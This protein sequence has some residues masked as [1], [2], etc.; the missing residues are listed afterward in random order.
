MA[1]T[2]PDLAVRS[3]RVLTAEGLREGT[4]LIAG[5][6]I[7]D[8]VPWDDLPETTAVDDVGNLV[9]MPGLVDTHVHINEPGRT[10]W[11]GFETATKAAAAGGITTLGDMP[12]NSDPVTT[13]VAAL[14]EKVAAADG[15]LWAD[16]GFFGGV[17]PSNAAALEPLVAAGVLGFK[18][19]LTFS[20]IDEFPPVNE[21]DLRRVLPL[22]TEA[23]R[24]LLVHAEL[25][26]A[27]GSKR[28]W[29]KYSEYLASRPPEWEHRAIALL[30]AL[31]REYGCAVHIVHLSSAVAI[32]ALRSAREEGL[33]L[34]VET[35]P[36]YLFFA[37]EEITDGDTRFKCAPPIRE[38]DNR[39]RLWNALGD[40]VIDLVV[41]DHSPCPPE[42][43]QLEAG[44]FSQAWGGIAS[45]QFS[46]PIVWTEARKHGHSIAE[47]AAWMC[48]GPA[49]LAGLSGSKGT[50]APGYD[51]DLA[52][53]NP[54]GSFTV[55]PALIRHRHAVT[56]Y[57]GKTLHGVVEKTFLRGMK[58]YE[59]GKE[60]GAPVGRALYRRDG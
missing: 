6:R 41:S 52:I 57:E 11:E 48:S 9:V 20:G 16:C 8:V 54:E 34:T 43:K 3:R 2:F 40:G 50:L 51:A 32:T 45:L 58:T 36:H 59:R 15:K 19:F 30:V 17:I 21:A 23:G 60:P 1:H 26:G 38:E 53:W 25:G 14:R 44:D 28:P 55:K 42:L 5:G 27:A 33:A 24:P 18:A 7:L 12:L 37:S 56:P 4:V 49:R 29:R 22:L 13:S 35:C 47:L 31:S 46:L 39:T 10:A